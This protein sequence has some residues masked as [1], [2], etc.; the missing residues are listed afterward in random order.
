MDLWHMNLSI[1]DCDL[2]IED[3]K[4]RRANATMAHDLEHYNWK[5]NELS[6][7]K[8]SL[9]KEEIQWLTLIQ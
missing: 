2:L 4:T 6:K 5:I 1:E 3:A 9:K 7:I 8:R